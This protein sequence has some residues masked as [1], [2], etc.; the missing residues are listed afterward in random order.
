M[1]C[2]VGFDV[3]WPLNCWEDVPM[4]VLL[5]GSGTIPPVLLDTVLCLL[6]LRQGH[7]LPARREIIDIF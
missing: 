4:E 5:G 3:V 2:T 7:V 1:P 6:T